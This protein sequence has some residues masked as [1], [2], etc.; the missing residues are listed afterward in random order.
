MSI[1][2]WIIEKL[3]RSEDLEWLIERLKPES[4]ECVATGET[5]ITWTD[6]DNLVEKIQWMFF[7]NN[8]TGERSYE[9]HSYGLA[10][11]YDTH[12]KWEGEAKKYVATGII[13]V[14][15]EAV[16]FEMLKK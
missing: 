1:R 4:V 5:R 9:F 14:W 13:P 8:I 11:D 12:E 2:S 7:K 15:A 10:K 16:D 3:I 6:R